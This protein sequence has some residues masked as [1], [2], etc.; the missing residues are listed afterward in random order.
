M[1]RRAQAVHIG[2]FWTKYF[3]NFNLFLKAVSTLI[4]FVAFL[5]PGAGMIISLLILIAEIVVH[6]LT[7]LQK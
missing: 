1:G 4:F 3:L 7:K 5:M 2:K 6:K